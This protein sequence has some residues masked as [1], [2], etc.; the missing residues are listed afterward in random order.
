MNDEF[1]NNPFKSLKRAG[2][3]LKDADDP[4]GKK[5]K[6]RN[7]YA[8][9]AP[10]KPETAPEPDPGDESLAAEDALFLRAMGRAP[11]RAAYEAQKKAQAAT[12]REQDGDRP[13]AELLE[14]HE[15]NTKKAREA[16]DAVPPQPQR[17]AVKS[18]P[19]PPPP[20][21]LDPE[22]EAAFLSAMG[23]V[24]PMHPGSGRDVQPAVETPEPAPPKNP[25]ALAR[26]HLRRLVQGEIDFQL[27][28]TEEY[29][30][31]HVTGLDPK[32][33]NKLRA[34]SYTVE[35]HLD[36]HGMN[37]EQALLSTVDFIRRNY[38]LGRRTLLLVTGRGKNSPGGHSV[39]RDEVQTWLTREPLRRVV[40]AFVTAKPRD[41]GPGALY[42]MLRKYKKSLG[43]VQWDR[44]PKEWSVED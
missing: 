20:P 28:F 5:K 29:Q 16:K 10:A 42:V 40:L 24:K 25:D 3:N 21:D 12:P 32:I 13:F 9:P 14:E 7:A 27:E 39:L 36:L 15:K 4:D 1:E 44:L 31:G 41:G 35:A 2:L 26:E 34:G 43:K 8:P 33:F 38:L 37:A 11:G 30:H 23:D 19:A 6:K 22:E 18:A 17:P